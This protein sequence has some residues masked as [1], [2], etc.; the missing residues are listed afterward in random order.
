M[1]VV[2]IFLAVLGSIAALFVI[3]AALLLWLFDPNDYK[4]YLTDWVAQRTG[5]SFAV[6]DDLSLSFFPWLAVETGG[7]V[8]G[9]AEG[10]TADNFA[11]IEHVSARVKLWPLFRRQVEIGTIALD[12]LQLDLARDSQG[13]NNWSDLTTSEASAPASEPAAGVDTF[14]NFGVESVQ[15]RGAQLRWRENDELRYI[16]SDLR[17]ET[18]AIVP[19][20][21]IDIELELAALDV[22]SQLSLQ[23]ATRTTARLTA[24]GGVEARD[25]NAEFMLQDAAQAERARGTLQLTALDLA[26]DG[27]LQ[28]TELT[29]ASRVLQPPV[30]PDQLDVILAAQSTAYDPT[31][32]SLTIDELTSSVAG[33]QAR[34][35]VA[36]EA[37]LDD[38]QLA[39]TVSI[40]AVSLATVVDALELTL[41]DDMNRNALG[42]FSASSSFRSTLSSGQAVFD[43]LTASLLGMN[44]QGRASIDGSDSLTARIDVPSF[45]VGE[46]LRALLRA[47]L[48]ADID[49]GAI[50]RLAIR[51]N[52][53]ANLSSSAYAIADMN[54]ELLGAT[55]SGQ[56]NVSQANGGTLV[57]GALKSNRFASA[58]F[59]NAFGAILTDTVD[60]RELGT[61]AF[62]TRFEYNARADTLNLNPL[63]LE[64]FGLAATGRLSAT[65]LSTV[66]AF[67]GNAQIQTFA[68][69]EL[70]RR[71]GQTPP[72]ASDD[73]VL[74][75]ARIDT[76]FNIT[77]KLGRFDELLLVLD[78]TRFS[79]NFVVDDFE[80][81]SYRFNLT[82]DKLDVDRY[83]PPPA[84]QAADGERVA[85]DIELSKEALNTIRISGH[86]EVND[87]KLAGLSFQQVATDIDFGAGKADIG[88]ARARLYGGEFT[89]GLNVDASGDLP[90][91]A[92]T[93][94]ARQLAL[95][96]LIEA[97]LGGEANFSGT[98]NFDIRL[99]GRGKT[100]TDTVASAAGTM[101]FALSNGAISGFNLGHTLCQV[102]N[103]QQRLPAP[104]QQPK[105]TRYELLQGSA[106]VDNGIAATPDL[107]ARTAFMDITGRGRLVL[108]EQSLDYT[109]ESKLTRSL[110]IQGCESL[111]GMIGDSF[112]WTLKG[113]VTEA[114]ILPDFSKYLRQ[115]VEDEIKDRVRD[116]LE[117]RLRGLL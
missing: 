48:P 58:S 90:T 42:N 45:A 108:V 3:A 38:P 22:A 117:D 84:D 109:L 8:I 102:Y 105:E 68:P 50:D 111:D 63:A 27:S 110:G 7:I 116:R 46:P 67:A 78:D 95:E 13:R 9:N 76:S 57:T 29:L 2:K 99:A 96:P 73:T 101:S 75:S 81:P 34:W 5:R 88:N 30:G 18:G 79:G 59:A 14:T 24:D 43:D 61:L 107:L 55:L 66:P 86:A 69:R 82:A 115:R 93:G 83:L 10:F 54:A 65:A 103:A 28:L 31:R 25:V 62:D 32:Q 106:R 97:L 47:N 33:I 85:G 71:F 35:R 12:G 19:D 91:M 64:V 52:I 70:F 80:N 36:A 56:I 89:G 4:D 20:A 39:G 37:L 1:K 94:Q 74:R 114:E 15:I 16:V 44:V 100:I 92:L 49:V 41:P 21:A 17:F 77:S 113:T 60:P 87:L 72:Q 40:D 53:D 51:G 23:L 98:G 11:T 104:P 112:P 26:A 6:R